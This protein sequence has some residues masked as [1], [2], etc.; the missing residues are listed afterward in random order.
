MSGIPL[1]FVSLS[2]ALF[3]SLVFLSP[4]EAVSVMS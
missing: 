3:L 2:P 1:L 4:R